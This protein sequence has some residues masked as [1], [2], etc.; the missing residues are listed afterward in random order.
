[1]RTRILLHIR[2][3]R[4]RIIGASEQHTLPEGEGIGLIW[5]LSSIT[6]VEEG[7]AAYTP[8]S[9]AYALSRDIPAV[10]RLFV[11]PIVRRVCTQIHLPSHF[12]KPRSPLTPR[13]RPQRSNLRAKLDDCAAFYP[14][15]LSMITVVFGADFVFCS[16]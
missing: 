6:R 10:L 7:M 3:V 15:W 4:R 13:R 1:M 12:T 14:K 2:G 11:S 8:K 9:R 16:V 5:H